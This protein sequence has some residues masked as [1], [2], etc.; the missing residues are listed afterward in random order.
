MR[1]N[2]SIISYPKSGRTW[3]RAL[4]GKYLVSKYKLSNANILETQL[5][6]KKVN[7]PQVRFTH[8]GSEWT[9]GDPPILLPHIEYYNLIENKDRYANRKVILLSR[10]VKD[11]LVS[12]YFQATKRENVFHGKIS[13]FIR[14]DKFGAKRVLTFYNIWRKNKNIPKEFMEITYEDLHKNTSDVLRN[15]LSFIGEKNISQTNIDISVEFCSFENLHN[16]EK[17]NKFNS[18]RLKAG[19]NKDPES[20][21][22]RKG[23]IGGYINYLSRE[24]I[25]YIHI[26]EKKFK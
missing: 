17:E 2:V 8:N 7:L 6:T 15:T 24:D 12:A 1:S 25:E 16:V 4:I 13:D 10:D 22:V 19:S 14:S 18:F 20:F 26:V 9:K 21:K 3:L 5:L 23:E 11:T